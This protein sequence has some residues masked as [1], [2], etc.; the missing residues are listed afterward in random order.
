MLDI[1][2]LKVYGH[3][4]MADI[5]SENPLPERTTSVLRKSYE[6]RPPKRLSRRDGFIVAGL[7]LMF[8]VFPTAD[9]AYHEVQK[10][11][12]SLSAS[13]E[14]ETKVTPRVELKM[15]LSPETE[16]FLHE[17]E[18]LLLAGEY[19]EA[20][21]MIP[22][23]KLFIVWNHYRISEDLLRLSIPTRERSEDF[24]E[25]VENFRD[26]RLR[27]GRVREVHLRQLQVMR[28]LRGDRESS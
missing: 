21:N 2:Y 15:R 1:T 16:Q 18:R 24:Y 11:R 7:W 23:E 28:D 9:R 8:G 17:I 20:A 5:F 12:V 3:F 25:A 13:A 26:V 6:R 22:Q 10:E 4:L 27:L 14:V 19:E